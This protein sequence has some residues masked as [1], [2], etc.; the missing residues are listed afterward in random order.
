MCCIKS[1]NKYISQAV[2]CRNRVDTI[3]KSLRKV[4]LGGLGPSAKTRVPKSFII[5]LHFRISFVCESVTFMLY[6]CLRFLPSGDFVCNILALPFF[7][8]GTLVLALRHIFV[9]GC[10]KIWQGFLS[11]VPS[12][13][14]VFIQLSGL[15]MP[16]FFCKRI[17]LALEPLGKSFNNRD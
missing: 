12:L 6:F 1:H 14:H 7:I 13:L 2:T 9:S 8:F 10:L 11:Y 15:R 5:K 17:K 16:R 3:R 4:E